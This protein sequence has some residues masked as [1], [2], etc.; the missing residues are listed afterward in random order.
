M[1]VVYTHT[2]TVHIHVYIIYMHIYIYISHVDLKNQH[3]YL[4]TPSSWISPANAVNLASVGLAVFGRPMWLLWA[5][6]ATWQTGQTG[7]TDVAV[8]DFSSG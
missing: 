3:P 5:P 2:Y 8:A 7:Q 1:L 6:I 4:Y